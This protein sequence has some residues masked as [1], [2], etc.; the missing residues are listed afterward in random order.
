[1]SA[2]ILLKFF[3]YLGLFLAGGLGVAGG[4]IQSAHRQA[5]MPPAEPVQKAMRK[6][7]WLS[8]VAIIILWVTGIGLG[9][10]IY[11]TLSLGWAFSMKIAGASI[12]LVAIALVNLTLSRAG[13]TGQP[14]S[15]WVMKYAPMASR[16]ALVLVLAGIAITTTS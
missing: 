12:L 13:Q 15:A 9:H 2:I 16:G 6:M 4:F 14:P 5:A 10:M 1:M 8:L 7:A 3:H 11:G